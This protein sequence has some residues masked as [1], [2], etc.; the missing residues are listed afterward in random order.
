MISA[1]EWLFWVCLAVV[2]YAYALYPVAL[3]AACHIARLRG[4]SSD[5]PG[6]EPRGDAPPA[7][8]LPRVS[9]LV[10]AYNEEEHLPAKLQNVDRIDYPSD[11]LECVFVSDGSADATDGILESVRRP[12]FQFHRLASRQGK[13]TALNLAVARAH[14]EILVFS[15]ASTM[16]EPGAVGRL[17][18]HFADPRV[19]VVCGSIEFTRT[20]ES[21]ATEGVYW[22]YETA[23]REMEGRIGATLTASGAIYAVRRCCYRPLAPG[24]I[25]DDF[26]VPMTARRLGY[27][28]EYEPEARAMETAAESVKG[29]FTRRVRLAAGSF[30]SLGTLTRGALSSPVVLWAF[31]SHK[32]LRWL[33]PLF[34]LALLGASV[35][36]R[37][38][39]FYGLA[40][41]LQGAFCFW[42]LLGWSHRKQLEKVRFALVGYFLVAMNMAFLMG[43]ARSLVGRQEVTWTRVR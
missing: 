41:T 35:A 10:A 13:P 5:S 7:R 11:R 19:G 17:V 28:V 6:P 20:G 9:L 27:R 40:L 4:A 2:I 36:L 14:G 39:P 15:D 43:L 24:A 18:R 31:L 3:A 29:E 34:L 26:L 38:N 33:A 12:G 22:R 42:A 23:L 1:T 30:R 32:A 8:D 25:L 16:F 21:A 37:H